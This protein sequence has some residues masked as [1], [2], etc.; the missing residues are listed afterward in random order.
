MRPPKWRWIPGLAALHSGGTRP[1]V[2]RIAHADNGF[3][4]IDLW[5]V[6]RRFPAVMVTCKGWLLTTQIS[7]DEPVSYKLWTALDRTRCVQSSKTF[8]MVD[9]IVG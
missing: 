8:V 9:R 4:I 6:A 1:G 3:E 7:C 2:A 5:G